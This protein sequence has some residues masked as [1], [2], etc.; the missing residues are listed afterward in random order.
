MQVKQTCF[1]LRWDSCVLRWTMPADIK[2]VY[3]SCVQNQ[4]FFFVFTNLKHWVFGQ[5]VSSF[6]PWIL[7]ELTDS[8]RKLHQMHRQ[9]NHRTKAPCA[10]RHAIPSWVGCEISRRG[11]L[12]GSLASARADTDIATASWR[13]TGFRWSV[14]TYTRR[15]SIFVPSATTRTTRLPA[16][17]TFSLPDC[18]STLPL[19]SITA[20]PA[21][22]LPIPSGRFQH[23][24]PCDAGDAA[25]AGNA[26][27]GPDA[28]GIL[29]CPIHVTHS[30][31]ANFPSRTVGYA[32]WTGWLA[33]VLTSSGLQRRRV[34]F[35][36]NELAGNERNL[37]TLR[38]TRRIPHYTT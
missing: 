5:F 12:V 8:G 27:D 13:A 21:G 32:P 38:T 30:C 34:V 16:T 31:P 6:T 4:V 9:P 20:L 3:D 15:S 29:R 17:R 22:R 33:T 7:R 24:S 1:R 23:T 37:T 28:S 25:D 11:E 14:P 18:P 36:R 10:F 35:G 2:Q 19:S 26:G